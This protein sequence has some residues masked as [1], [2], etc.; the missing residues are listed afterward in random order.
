MFG[1]ILRN[2]RNMTGILWGGI[3]LIV[4]TV[5]GGGRGGQGRLIEGERGLVH[6]GV[7]GE[8]VRDHNYE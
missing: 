6:I 8:T 5:I 7:V 2:S 3:S 1:M 4:R